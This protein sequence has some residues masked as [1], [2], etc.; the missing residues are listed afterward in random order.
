MEP[1]IIGNLCAS[2][3]K[4][5][6]YTETKPRCFEPANEDVRDLD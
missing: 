4:L 5:S 1:C 6:E 2:G 3:D